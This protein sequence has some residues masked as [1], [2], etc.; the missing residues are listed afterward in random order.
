M[1]QIRFLARR[2][3]Q[4]DMEYRASAAT[5]SR[6]LIWATKGR[7]LELAVSVVRRLWSQRPLPVTRLDSKLQKTVKVIPSKN[8]RL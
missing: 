1:V 6:I 4:T 2:G 5:L 7:F 8:D 3:A